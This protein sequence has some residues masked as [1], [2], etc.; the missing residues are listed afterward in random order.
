[1]LSV[2]KISLTGNFINSIFSFFKGR[3][4]IFIGVR[5]YHIQEKLFF[6]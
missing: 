4:P 3:S 1:M 5:P 2:L 6:L